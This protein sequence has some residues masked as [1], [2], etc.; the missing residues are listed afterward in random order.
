MQRQSRGVAT[1]I[2]GI[3]LAFTFAGA[4]NAVQPPDAWVTTQVKMSLLT[5][6]GVSARNVHVDTVEGRVTLH[7]SVPTEAEK[8]RAQEVAR[9]IEGAREVR[10]LL[11]VVPRAGKRSWSEATRS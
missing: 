6:E 9:K 8:A 5:S 11:Q 10:N 4:A 1:A 7:G 3:A 2:F